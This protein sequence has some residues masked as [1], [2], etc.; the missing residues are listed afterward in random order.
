MLVQTLTARVM[1]RKVRTDEVQ[2][3]RVHVRDVLPLVKPEQRPG[4]VLLLGL[5][6]FMV[7][8]V[9]R[10][11]GADLP[12]LAC[13]QQTFGPRWWLICPA[14]KRRCA[15]LYWYG[16]REV[17]G[18]GCRVCLKIKYTSSATHRTPAGDMAARQRGPSGN[19]A[20]Y[21]RAGERE[22]RRFTKLLRRVERLQR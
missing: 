8:V 7:D 13:T 4:A 19:W 20:A 1:R 18:W 10:E 14:C 9:T 17:G 6:P 12:S 16:H 5:T 2:A 11:H 3:Y 21:E 15:C 22:R